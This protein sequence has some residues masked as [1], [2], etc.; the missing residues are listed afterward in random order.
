V[1]ETSEPK[2]HPATSYA[3]RRSSSARA[4]AAARGSSRKSGTRCEVTLGHRLFAEGLRYRKNVSSLPGCPD[5]VFVRARVAV[6]CDG[7]FWHGRDWE[8]RRRKLA[9]GSNASYWVAKI[10]RNLERD[11]ESTARL[12]ALG[13]RVVRL[14]ESQILGDPEG[15]VRQVLTAL[16]G[17]KA[18][19]QMSAS[20]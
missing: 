13:W 2:K 6:F 14:W 1:S 8:S 5:I 11:R 9:A 10:A 18:G 4:S 17:S 19:A 20:S 3:G 16:Q 12:E 15:A 7:D